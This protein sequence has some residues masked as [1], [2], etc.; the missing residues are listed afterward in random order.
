MYASHLHLSLVFFPGVKHTLQLVAPINAPTFQS[1][2]CSVWSPLV[3]ICVL[4]VQVA[5][6]SLSKLWSLLCCGEKMTWPLSLCSKDA[7]PAHFIPFWM[8]KFMECPKHLM[9]DDR[10]ASTLAMDMLLALSV[11]GAGFLSRIFHSS[12]ASYKTDPL[13][14]CVCH[15]RLV[16]AEHHS[17]FASLGQYDDKSQLHRLSFVHVRVGIFHL[18][19]M[20]LSVNPVNFH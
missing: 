9:C 12:H 14:L 4:E 11:T 8:A 10:L 3:L 17:S 15:S 13:L 16:S 19:Y 7:A 5:S 18:P 20:P 6:V 2:S 1:K